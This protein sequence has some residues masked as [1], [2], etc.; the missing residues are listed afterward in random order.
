MSDNTS[1]VLSAID[2]D[3]TLRS[4]VIR[5]LATTHAHEFVSPLRAE[6]RGNDDIALASVNSNKEWQE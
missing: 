5:H 4:A 3:K 6:F 2:S 1:A